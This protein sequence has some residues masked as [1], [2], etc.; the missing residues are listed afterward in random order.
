MSNAVSSLARLLRLFALALGIALVLGTPVRA[1]D[2]QAIA[3]QKAAREFMALTDRGDAAGSWAKAGA[4]FQRTI[5]AQAWADALKGARPPLGEMIRRTLETSQ[6]SHSFPNMPQGDYAL[7]LFR[8]S[9]TNKTDALERVTLER[10]S[11]GN[12]HV[13]G[14]FIQ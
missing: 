1:Q 8:S 10:Q 12:W 5:S 7:L 13:I 6:F 2:P 4:Q 11:D 9:F 3:A 14:Y